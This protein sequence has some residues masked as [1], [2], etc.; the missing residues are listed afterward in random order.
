[1]ATKSLGPGI[2]PRLMA[3][4]RPTSE[5]PSDSVPRSR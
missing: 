2:R 5:F 3:S 1:M 4:R